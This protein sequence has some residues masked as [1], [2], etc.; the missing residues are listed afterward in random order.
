MNT[1][2]KVGVLQPDNTV[3]IISNYE[4]E[5]ILNASLTMGAD[6]AIKAV[7]NLVDSKE[8]TEADFTDALKAVVRYYT[9]VEHFRIC[10]HEALT[11]EYPES[12]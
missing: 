8:P 10:V 5:N 9:N 7:M 1:Q 3:R 6:K 12:L 4:L 11:G 2:T